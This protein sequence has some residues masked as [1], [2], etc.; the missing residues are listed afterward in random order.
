[1]HLSL[2]CVTKLSP[3]GSRLIYSTYCGRSA[4]DAASGIAVDASGQAYVPGITQ[5]PDFPTAAGHLTGGVQHLLDGHLPLELREVGVEDRPY[6]R[7]TRTRRG[8]KALSVPLI[9]IGT[10][11]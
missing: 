9:L 8:R 10:G 1:M 4:T 6:V 7:P 3:D 11:A 5:S 2:W